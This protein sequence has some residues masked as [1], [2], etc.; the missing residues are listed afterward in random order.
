[1]SYD[2]CQILW[3]DPTID[4]TKDRV[5]GVTISYAPNVGSLPAIDI[6]S[7]GGCYTSMIC[8]DRP[9]GIKVRQSTVFGSLNSIT[10][11][12][13]PPI[14]DPLMAIFSM[15]SV[16]SPGSLSLST[17]AIIH[18][19]SVNPDLG[20]GASQ[21]SNPIEMPN[22]N[23]ITGAEGYGI[24]K[25]PGTHSSIT[26]NKTTGSDYP[27]FKFGVLCGQPDPTT[28]PTPT[29][30]QEISC[31]TRPIKISIPK[32]WCETESELSKISIRIGGSD[33]CGQS[34]IVDFICPTRTPTPTTT[35]TR[36]PTLSA[37]PTPTQTNTVPQIDASCPDCVSNLILN[38]GFEQ[39]NPGSFSGGGT[40]TNWVQSNIDVHS[41]SYDAGLSPLQPL[42]RWV[43]LN[44]TSPGYIQQ[45]ISTT[46]GQSYTISFNLAANNFGARTTIKTCRL[47]VIGSSTLT[48]D[49]SFNPSSTTYGTYESMGWIAQTYT[50]VADNSSTTI[51]FESTCPSCFQFGPAI[52]CVCVQADNSST[53]TPTPTLSATPTRTPNVTPTPTTT[54]SATPTRTPDVTPTP[55]STPNNNC[56]TL[57]SW[58]GNY[59]G[60][61]G[62]G[63]S[64]PVYSTS[65]LN[66]TSS[67][68]E[69]ISTN[70]GSCFGI[71]KDGYLWAWGD[72]DNRQLGA[73]SVLAN[74]FLPTKVGNNKWKFISSGGNT[75]LG[76]KDD[77]TLWSWGANNV[78]QL[79]N[80]TY[81][82]TPVATPTQI[83]SDSWIFVSA[84]SHCL[85]IKSNGTLW[86]WGGNY[87]GQLGNGDNS[88]RVTTPIQIG[89]DTWNKVS[90]GSGPDGASYS[91]GI[92]SD[93]SLWGWGGNTLSQLGDGTTTSTNIPIKIGNDTWVEI[94]AGWGTTLGIKS[95]GTLWGWGR[96]DY[97]QLGNG[98]NTNS[99]T[100]VQIGN[101]TWLK[102]SV[103]GHVL[104][105]KNDGT[106]WSWGWNTQ[107]QL[108]YGE[109]GG[110]NFQDSNIP[111]KIGNETWVSVA[112]GIFNSLGISC[113]EIINPTPTPTVTPTSTTTLSATPN[114]TPTPTSTLSATPT[115]TTSSVDT[116]LKT[117]FIAWVPE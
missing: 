116:N 115:P 16:S 46:V 85:G 24:V 8:P 110:P 7:F 34:N 55:S 69:F 109:S 65:P 76:I 86:G 87:Y 51:K 1:M 72:N 114:A 21:T 42:K 40:I 100:H 33:C 38:G 23:I 36:T 35:P 5:N 77:G 97:G 31:D 112:A 11:N 29:P 28:T 54:L 111:I 60:E 49:Y 47:S 73:G 63:Q 53:S 18:C 71:D 10:V 84:G 3:A 39:G 14:T 58:G 95:N 44:K 20:C 4:D 79:G 107:G 13:D 43:D 81:G 2:D 56:N 45:T 41:L 32:E 89:S 17:P 26:I 52:D 37:T 30:T 105:I 82:S 64:N 62:T 113:N 12:F 27:A 9:P 91:M 61:L 59:N 104:A 68:W 102:A 48:Q 70:G 57:Y 106:L 22:Q 92:K 98:N 66:F 78:G 117:M 101:E 94:Y 75:T 74:I 96:N 103:Y 93:G 25:F 99:S 108:G 19:N 88:I 50:F 83:S 6:A 67:D 90:V 15:A 80:G